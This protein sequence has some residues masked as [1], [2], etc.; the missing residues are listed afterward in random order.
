MHG[1]HCAA[2]VPAKAWKLQKL[3]AVGGSLAKDC[4]D[5]RGRS[6][7]SFVVT[8]WANTTGL[9]QK[10]VRGF[11]YG[12]VSL[13]DEY[14]GNSPRLFLEHHG[15]N[16]CKAAVVEK[17]YG[18]WTGL[19]FGLL[20]CRH[21]SCGQAPHH[22]FGQNQT[23]TNAHNEFLNQPFCTGGI[24]FGVCRISGLLRCVALKTGKKNQWR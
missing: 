18:R 23:L 10:M 6:D 7:A 11:Q 4:S 19:L 20:L 14:W 24:G 2:V 17:A 21:R 22:Y 3:S 8:I 12:P 13:F 5:R 9:L 16:V 1:I 15:G